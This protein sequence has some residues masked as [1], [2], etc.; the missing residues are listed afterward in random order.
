MKISYRSVS[1]I[2]SPKEMKNI[3]GGSGQGVCCGWAYDG[4]IC[5]RGDSCN[6]EG[7][8]GCDSHNLNISMSCHYYT[9]DYCYW[10]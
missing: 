2:L 1:D 4:C 8:A 5:A 6:P 3:T 9:P 7:G 10:I